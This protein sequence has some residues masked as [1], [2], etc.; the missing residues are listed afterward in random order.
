[1]KVSFAI[2]MTCCS[3]LTVA[4]VPGSD[5]YVGDLQVVEGQL[6]ISQLQALTQRPQYDNQPSFLLDGH[7]LLIS[8]AQGEGVH[9]QT[10]SV[11]YD[12]KS[13]HSINITKTQVS[14][15]SPTQMPNK[16][17][18]SV[19]HADGDLQKLWRY[20]L[21]ANAGQQKKRPPSEL[22]ADIN[23]VGY[24]AWIDAQRV[25]LFVLGEPHSLQL[26]NIKTQHSE[27]LDSNIGPSLFAIP[28]SNL[29]SYTA[30][31]DDGDDPSWALKSYDPQSGEIAILTHLPKGAYYYGWSGDAKAIAAQGS[32]LKQWDSQLSDPKW[33]VFGDVSDICPLGVTRLTTNKQNSKIALV[34]T[35]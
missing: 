26:A 15:Y 13:G 8:G 21:P 23:P 14:E 25:L 4:Q 3:F 30:T 33:T 18:F 11:L 35:Q 24:H 7:Q 9:E 2:S 32:V 28:H 34:C 10:D 29:M 22:L 20:P 12:L 19:I 31:T 1:M 27:I 5:L 16:I 17:D 6:Q